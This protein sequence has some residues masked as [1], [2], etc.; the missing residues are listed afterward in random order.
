MSVQG[1]GR[2]ILGSVILVAGASNTARASCGISDVPAAAA[3]ALSG[4]L[5]PSA[6]QTPA[7]A[8]ATPFAVDPSIVGLWHTTFLITVNGT[9]VPIQEAFQLWNV[10][11]TEIHNPRV[12]PRQGNVCLGVWQQV[13]P[14]TFK[15]THRV[16][17]WDTSGGFQGTLHLAE[18]LTLG[19][20][21]NTFGGTFTLGIYDP[22]GA[23]VAEVAGTA[24]G[25][26]IAVGDQ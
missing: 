22:S 5:S 20:G 26:R 7:P 14:R 23:R 2:I 21:G 15:L 1:I 17:A 9:Q 19:N 11:G 25:E 12:D 13:A 4:R 6:S 10:G 24:T 3:A 16:W 18:T 8:A